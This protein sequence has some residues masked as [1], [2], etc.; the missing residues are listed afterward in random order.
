MRGDAPDAADSLEPRAA[1]SWRTQVWTKG[2][3]ALLPVRSCGLSDVAYLR[4]AWQ[5]QFRIV[6]DDKLRA[7]QQKAFVLRKVASASD[8]LA[9]KRAD[10]DRVGPP[11]QREDLSALGVQIT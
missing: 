6:V 8:V 2:Y 5:V 1:T 10:G 4:V 3:F 9:G 11:A 7:R